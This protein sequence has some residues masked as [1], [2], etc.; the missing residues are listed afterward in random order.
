[1]NGT[2]NNDKKI[3]MFSRDRFIFLGVVILDH[4]YLSKLSQGGWVTLQ[5]ILL[6]IICDLGK[7]YL[8]Y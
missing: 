8:L 5:N 2:E 6:K 4:P 7:N 1:M 3:M